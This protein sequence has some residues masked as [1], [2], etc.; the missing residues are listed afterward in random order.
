[1][2]KRISFAIIAATA[3]IAKIIFFIVSEI[4]RG[5]EF[6]VRV[7]GVFAVRS[8]NEDERGQSRPSVQTMRNESPLWFFL[9]NQQ[10]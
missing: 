5:G 9:F 3:I 10:N 7:R 4:L 2:K 8:M 6:A 1:M